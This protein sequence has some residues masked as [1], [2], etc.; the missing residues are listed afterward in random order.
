MSRS[1]RTRSKSIMSIY[2]LA[3]E[4]KWKLKKLS[5][6]FHQFLWHLFTQTEKDRQ[7]ESNREE[8]AG[9]AVV[10]HVHIYSIVHAV[11]SLVSK[12]LFF[13]KLLTLFF[14]GVAQGESVQLL[15]GHYCPCGQWWRG[16]MMMIMG[17][18]ACL[19]WTWVEL[20]HWTSLL[21]MA[22]SWQKPL[23]NIVVPKCTLYPK[24]IGQR[25]MID[26]WLCY[27]PCTIWI[28]HSSEEKRFQLVA[29]WWWVGAADGEGCP[30]D[31]VNPNG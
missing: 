1:C 30:T 14:S 13:N 3:T 18:M 22:W 17:G 25:S 6:Q 5:G 19:I 7:A 10:F 27:L 26:L 16:V 12:N 28:E 23:L 29:I 15:S 11:K 24:T 4:Q 8:Q 20:C 2:G 21:V 9:K 31:L